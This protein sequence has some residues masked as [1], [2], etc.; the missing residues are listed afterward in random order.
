MTQYDMAMRGLLL[1]W[2]IYGPR[3][4]DFPGCYVIRPW[5]VGPNPE[6]PFTWQTK[7]GAFTSCVACV[8]SSLREARGCLGHEYTLFPRADEDDP[9]IVESWI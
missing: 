7:D 4:K 6:W 2:T 3:T 5:V 8:C 1:G 9:V